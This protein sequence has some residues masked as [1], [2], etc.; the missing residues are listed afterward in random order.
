[1]TSTPPAVWT[2]STATRKRPRVTPEQAWDALNAALQKAAPP[3]DG[4]ALFTADRLTDEQRAA[5]ASICATCPLL[6]LCEAYAVTARVTSGFWAG[7][8]YT[9]K[10]T[11]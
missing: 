9:S 4:R 2:S 8:H 11:R 3:C 10:G 6:D 1:M 5:C 7:E